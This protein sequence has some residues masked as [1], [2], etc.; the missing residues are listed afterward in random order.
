MITTHALRHACF[1]VLIGAVAGASM[2]AHAGDNTSLLSPGNAFTYQGIS[3]NADSYEYIIEFRGQV[4][5]WRVYRFLEDGE[6]PYLF[7]DTHFNSA[8]VNCDDEPVIPRPYIE[9]II[10]RLDAAE[11]YQP[12]PVKQGDLDY[13]V[14]LSVEH[15][16]L[17]RK[18]A[19]IPVLVRASYISYPDGETEILTMTRNGEL[20]LRL[21]LPDGGYERMTSIYIP[22]TPLAPSQRLRLK[23]SALRSFLNSG[24]KA[25]SGTPSLSLYGLGVFV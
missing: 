16:Y 15:S 14:S 6:D 21:D 24:E 5:P 4:C 19:N 25:L 23:S 10:R 7:A 12:I 1:S 2:S 22:E 9:A 17:D 18:L 20:F 13:T 8:Y 3:P 11:P